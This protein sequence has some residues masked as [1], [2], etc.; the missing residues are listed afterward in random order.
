MEKNCK[1][2]GQL[3]SL[4]NFYKKKSNKDGYNNICKKCSNHKRNIQRRKKQKQI[5]HNENRE[6]IHSML[7]NLCDMKLTYT[8]LEKQMKNILNKINVFNTE[9]T[10][11]LEINKPVTFKKEAFISMTLVS[12]HI[13]LRDNQEKT[14]TQT[15]I[16]YKLDTPFKSIKIKE[17]IEQK[18]NDY[19]S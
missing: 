18:I 5:N 12:Q 8:E 14:E 9:N 19:Q 6:K 1:S 2:C 16:I 7:L 17:E 15:K 10:Y 4:S 11:L 3:L 13:Y